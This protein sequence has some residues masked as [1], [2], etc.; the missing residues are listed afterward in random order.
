[1]KVYYYHYYYYDILYCAVARRHEQFMKQGH[2]YITIEE[3]G[4]AI[5]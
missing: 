2:I 5:R 3:I 1:M 4:R